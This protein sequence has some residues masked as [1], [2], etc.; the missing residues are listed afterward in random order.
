MPHN[1]GE[2]N[3]W[4]ITRVTLYDF[5]WLVYIIDSRDRNI[6]VWHDSIT[7]LILLDRNIGVQYIRYTSEYIPKLQIHQHSFLTR[8]VFSWHNSLAKV[9]FYGSSLDHHQRW[10]I[11]ETGSSLDHHQSWIIIETGSSSKLDHHWIVIITASTISI[12]WCYLSILLL[13]GISTEPALFHAGC[14]PSLHVGLH[15]IQHLYLT[16]GGTHPTSMSERNAQHLNFTMGVT[17][18]TSMSERHTQHSQPSAW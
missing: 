2:F 17:H 3:P 9:F 15:L 10:I 5:T 11:I 14:R 1:C 16:M 12:N 18:P 7:L 4:S 8:K 6:G 13:I